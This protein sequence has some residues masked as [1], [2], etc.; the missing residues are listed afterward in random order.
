MFML[1]PLIED[2][3]LSDV[4]MSLVTLGEKLFGLKFSKNEWE[5]S[6]TTN[7]SK[8]LSDFQNIIKSLWIN[9]Y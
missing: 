1:S 8:H 3:W 6:D 2:L 9:Q 4:V 7:I 5:N